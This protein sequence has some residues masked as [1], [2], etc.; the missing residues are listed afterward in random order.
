VDGGAP[1][2][3]NNRIVEN[4]ATGGSGGGIYYDHFAAGTTEGNVVA[5]NTCTAWG[6][7]IALWEGAKPNLTRN[8]IVAN[9]AGINGGGIYIERNS[10]PICTANVVAFHPAGG[11][12]FIQDV[13]STKIVECCDAFGNTPANYIGIPDPTGTSGNISADPLFCDLLSGDYGLTSL[14]PCS[15]PLSPSG[16]G[17]IGALDVACPPTSA[18]RSSWGGIKVRYRGEQ[19]P[20]ISR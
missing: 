7:G 5:R 13:Q 8:S 4:A 20:A 9:Q 6:G 15:L 12:V 2:I 16:C 17:Q 19:P 11:G 18:T 14:S 10:H 1:T 3:V